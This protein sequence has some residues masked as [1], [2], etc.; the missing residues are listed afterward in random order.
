M[1]D[2]VERDAVQRRDATLTQADAEG[3]RATLSDTEVTQECE[4]CL[5]SVRKSQREKSQ[6]FYFSF[7]V[8]SF[9]VKEIVAKD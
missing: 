8:K 3:C 6:V 7:F 9:L 2:N 1:G 5:Q 4:Q